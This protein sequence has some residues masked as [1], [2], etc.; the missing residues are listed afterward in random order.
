MIKGLIDETFTKF[1]DVVREG[2]GR[3]FERRKNASEQGRRLSDNWEEYADGR[4]L[5]GTEAFKHGFIDKLGNFED[6]VH[7][8]EKVAKIRSA[9]LIEYQQRYD[10]ADIFRLFGGTEAKSIKVNLG[11]EV[12][13]LQAGR[14]YFLAPTYL[15]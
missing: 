8:T 4:V 13:K 3:A 9:T 11:I 10:F 15:Q 5:S 12:P 6:A 2:R 7:L 1:K 14:L